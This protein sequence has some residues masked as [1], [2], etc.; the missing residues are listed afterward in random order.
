M[1]MIAKNT[2]QSH[3]IADDEYKPNLLIRGNYSNEEMSTSN[4]AVE[5]Y[6][7]KN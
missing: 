1:P 7:K 5:I 3:A 6:F 4:I 2:S